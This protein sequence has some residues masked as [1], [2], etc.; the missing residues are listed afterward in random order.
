MAGGNP[1]CRMPFRLHR[2]AES[3]PR[4][5][6]LHGLLKLLQIRALYPPF[7]A[8]CNGCPF[9]AHK[10]VSHNLKGLG[11]IPFYIYIYVVPAE[12]S[13]A[14]WF[15]T[16]P[17][18]P[19]WLANFADSKDQLHTLSL[20]C[21]VHKNTLPWKKAQ[22]SEGFWYCTHKVH[23]TPVVLYSLVIFS[24]PMRTVCTVGV[25]AQSH[26]FVPYFLTIFAQ[27]HRR[28]D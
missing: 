4:N 11:V 16:P 6:F 10:P 25:T 20:Y 15:G 3:I 9:Q 12:L 17:S 5:R 22:F 1:N 23:T 8:V 2:L 24:L 19:L 18:H 26:S 14:N 27:L 21:T 13:W 28:M 7:V